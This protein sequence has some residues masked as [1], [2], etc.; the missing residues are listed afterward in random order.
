LFGTPALPTAFTHEAEA[1]KVLAEVSRLNPGVEVR[2]E[3]WAQTYRIEFDG[4]ANWTLAEIY[5]AHSELSDPE[6]FGE[7]EISRQ[8]LCDMRIGETRHFA[9]GAAPLGVI[10]RIL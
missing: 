10:T 8:E 4:I 3:K 2:V 9:G 6:F 5:D 1:G 7:V